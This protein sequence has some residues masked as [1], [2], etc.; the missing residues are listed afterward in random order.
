MI[1]LGIDTS[2]AVCGLALSEAASGETVAMAQV[3]LQI[4]NAHSEK[5]M[6]LLAELLLKAGIDK[7]EIGAIAVSIGPGSFTGLRIGLSTAKGLAYGLRIPLAGIPTLDVIAEKAAFIE[8][9]LFVATSSRKNEF[10]F[11]SYIK[12]QRNSDYQVVSADELIKKI[13]PGTALICDAAEIIK[14]KIP[15][16]IKQEVR[17][18]EESWVYPDT[19]CLNKLGYR[20]LAMG[21]ADSLCALVPLYVQGFRGTKM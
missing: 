3:A 4:P 16:N 2:S 19:Y 21:Q 9:P 12:G 18:M 11:C 10:Y 13:K 6:P 20:K 14:E 1:I 15:E 8:N 17:F 7:K 5:I